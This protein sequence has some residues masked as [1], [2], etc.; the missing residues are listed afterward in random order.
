MLKQR[1]E[2][3]GRGIIGFTGALFAG[4][5]VAACSGSDASSFEPAT[6]DDPPVYGMLPTDAVLH[7]VLDDAALRALE[8]RSLDRQSFLVS[9]LRGVGF[10]QVPP[11]DI[12][13]YEYETPV[14]RN[15]SWQTQREWVAVHGFGIVDG[16][17]STAPPEQ[18]VPTFDDDDTG[19]AYDR[20]LDTCESDWTPPVERDSPEADPIVRQAAEEIATDADWLSAE[21]RLWPPCMARQGFQYT[22]IEHVWDEIGRR[23]EQ[24]SANSDPSEARAD[25]A[26][27]ERALA[28]ASLECRITEVIAEQRRIESEINRRFGLVT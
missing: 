27:Q 15:A 22:S 13:S 20:A 19:A 5:L 12:V 17:V 4:V 24:A 23:L 26:E 16:S 6:S 3:H 10:D 2:R 21:Q 9:C 11:R 25:L 8:Q 28:M 7:P 18:P 14:D 1:R